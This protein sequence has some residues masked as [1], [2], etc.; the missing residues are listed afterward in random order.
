ML[1]RKKIQ[2]ILK[3]HAG[4]RMLARRINYKIKRV[5][6]IRV[7]QKIS[8]EEKLIVFE[9]YMGRQYACSP[10]A[11]Y[12]EMIQDTR[13]DDY[14]FVW[15]F[16]NP[17]NKQIIKEL[18]RAELIKYKSDEYYKCYAKAAYI[19]TN[20]NLDY[21]ICKK[22]GQI[23]FQ[24]WHGTPL[25]RLRCDIEAEHGNANNTLD[26]IKWKNDIDAIRYD[27]F[28]SPS[29][30]ASEKFITAFRLKQL[31]RDNIILEEGYPRNDFLHHYSKNDVKQIK[32]KI[33]IKDVKKKVI[34]YAPTFRD[35]QHEAGQGYVY[36]TVLDFDKLQRA[37][38]DN[39]IVLFR[40]HYFIANQFDFDK[41]K[42]FVYDVT[43][44][45]DVK[46]LYVISDLLI[47]D[48]SSV[49]FDYAILKR[50]ILFY[51][52]DLQKYVNDIRGFYLSLDELPGRIVEK[53]DQLIQ[54]IKKGSFVYDEKYEAFNNKFNYLDDGHVSK[55]VIDKL[56]KL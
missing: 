21:A 25:K 41:Y 19:I 1:F 47:T 6:Y 42:G 5:K 20:S 18:K 23:F 12:E 3:R 4:L 14:K 46:E 53:E 28:L 33:G 8:V 9:S 56:F 52:Y 40:P 15:V 44:V 32:D 2:Q 37:L 49:F 17:E 16:Q 43:D 22:K 34:L 48:Y 11:I 13:F 30:F 38:G 39:Y 29:A 36:E 26:E 10:R 45:D 7:A 35:N 55:R 31:G 54:E 50:P 51:M 27:Y 24:T